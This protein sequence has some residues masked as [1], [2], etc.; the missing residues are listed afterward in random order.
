MTEP[1]LTNLTIGGIGIQV[2]GL[3]ELSNRLRQEP[4]P[5]PVGVLFLLH[6]RLGNSKQYY[7]KHIANL[8]LGEVASHPPAERARELIVVIL[9]QR[10]HGDRLVD[11]K[12]NEGWKDT[13]K[14]GTIADGKL[15]IQ[16]LDNISHL[17]DMYSLYTGTVNDVSFLITHL[18][19]LLFP[20]D[21]RTID[22]WMVMGISLGGHASWHIGAHDPRVSLI[23]PIIGSPD[24]LTLFTHRAASLGLPLTPPYLPNSL[25]RE[26]ERATPKIEDFK[27][28]DVLALSGAEDQLV[29]FEESG[30][31]AFTEQLRELNGC[32]SLEVWVQPAVGHTCSDEM[33]KR[34]K[35]FIWTK[36]ARRM[37]DK[38][39]PSLL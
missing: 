2:V 25:K 37:S 30:S 32:Q 13:G 20:Y 24:Y 8:V 27:D 33:M 29:G 1:S 39:G 31:K 23:V 17:H 14:V 11:A 15:D 28:K 16:S 26:I 34:A 38:A 4:E 21:E 18:Q 19:P 3:K 35:D 12:R 9:D 36:G 10:N 7:L 5:A 22:K 6:G